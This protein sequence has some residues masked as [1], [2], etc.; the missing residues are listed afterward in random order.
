M[1]KMSKLLTVA[2][3]AMGLLGAVSAQADDSNLVGT[4]ARIRRQVQ[5]FDHRAEGNHE[6]FAGDVH[7]EP[8]DDRQG[9]RHAHRDP[10]AFAG[11][12]VDRHHAPQRIHVLSDHVHPHPAAG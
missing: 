6:R 8:L 7:G 12:A 1:K 10:R 5:T 4:A 3:A 9:E 2:V 11:P